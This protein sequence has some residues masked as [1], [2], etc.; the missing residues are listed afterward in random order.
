MNE[1]GNDETATPRRR[2]HRESDL[3]PQ[4][5]MRHGTMA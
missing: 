4:K 3:S 5:A 1:S 2:E